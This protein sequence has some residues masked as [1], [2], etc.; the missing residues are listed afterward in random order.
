MKSIECSSS[1][2]MDAIKTVSEFITFIYFECTEWLEGI[3]TGRLKKLQIVTI[4]PER[5][6]CK[7]RY[8]NPQIIV[9]QYSSALAAALS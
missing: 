1:P 4:A 9:V 6:C 8:H 7:L 2:L 5:G 3:H